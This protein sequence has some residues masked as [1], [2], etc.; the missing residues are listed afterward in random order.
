[1][2]SS[3]KIRILSWNLLHKK[4]ASVDDIYNVIERINPDVLTLQEARLNIEEIQNKLGGFFIRTALP[5]REHGL[6]CWSKLSP[7]SPPISCTLPA[8]IIVKRT[9]LILKFESAIGPISI[10][11]VHLSHGQL[12]NRRQLRTIAPYLGNPGVIIGD[13]NLIGRIN[14][15]GFKE[16]GPH[17]PT[18]RML[19]HFPLRLDR[20]LVKGLQ[21]IQVGRLPKL[22]S[23]HHPIMIDLLPTPSN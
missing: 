13:F 9:A 11:N 14:L 22:G 1:M 12:L 21:S 17:I 8:G 18:H 4:G 15:K 5:G 23:D 20:C 3:P 6:A 19:N 7:I 2:L 16:V 10:A